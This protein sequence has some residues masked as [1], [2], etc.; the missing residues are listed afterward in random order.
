MSMSTK[1]EH[2]FGCRSAPAQT[3]ALGK[4]VT[5]EQKD[6]LWFE[7]RDWREI[8]RRDWEQHPDA[9]YA[10]SPEA[11]LYYLPSILLAVTEKPEEYFEPANA[12]L[13]ILDRTSNIDHWDAF[14]KNR[15]FGLSIEEYESLKAWV[16]S[17]SGGN[18]YLDEDAIERCYETVEL[19][20]RETERAGQQR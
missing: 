4:P 13:G 19:L 6:A 10:F 7:G 14:I 8:T 12:L 11:F 3:V 18:P 20:E 9:F 16:L 2:A 15:L 1:I 5:P 17:F